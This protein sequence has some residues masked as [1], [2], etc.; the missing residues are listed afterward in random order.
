MSGLKG[1]AIIGQSGGPTSV[2]NESLCG[3]IA[4]ALRHEEILGIY[5]AVHGIQGV[6]K[7]D[8]IDLRA[9][10]PDTLKLLARTPSAALGS[11]RKKPTRDE[12]GTIF[13]IFQA[14]EIRYFFYIGGNDSAETASIIDSLAKESG[15]ELRVCHIPKTIDNDLLVTDHCPGYGSAARF[16]ALALMGDNLDNLALKGVKINVIMGRHAG[17]LTAA[18]ALGRQ[19]EADGPHLVY[20]PEVPLSLEQLTS[21]VDSCMKRWDRC[22]VAVSEGVAD[23]NHQPLLTTG[24][25]DSHGNVQL[26]GTGALGDFLANHLKEK[27]G[28]KRVRADTFG[29]LQRSFP[30][31]VSDID[32]REAREVGAFGVQALIQ[33]G[34]KSCSISIRRLAPA[35]SGSSKGASAGYSPEYFLTDLKNVAKNTRSLDQEFI[36]A[37]GNNVTP[38]FLDYALP[39]I[40]PLPELGRLKGTPIPKKRV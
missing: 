36:A 7:Q 35:T 10:D 14:H 16:V 28:A 33:E 8:L 26:S 24:E 21:D 25:K 20:V 23:K 5:G 31:V 19:S 9:E 6:L 2:I 13:K 32:A 29:Y 27:L 38:L 3:V 11:V 4:A 12:C 17:F 39:L 15:Y 40:G 34:A 37:S 30:T 18:A 22:I 1:N